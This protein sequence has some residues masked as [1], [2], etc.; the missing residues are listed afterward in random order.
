[1][2]SIT[3]IDVLKQAE[4]NAR[5]LLEEAEQTKRRIRTQAEKKAAEYQEFLNHQEIEKMQEIKKKVE[6]EFL[7][8]ERKMIS[9]GTTK[10]AL[11]EAE[12]KKN[13]DKAVKMLVDKVVG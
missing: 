13:F 9:D 6:A 12:G 3:A 1:M 4:D 7:D 11:I 10:A 8:I 2:M 5:E